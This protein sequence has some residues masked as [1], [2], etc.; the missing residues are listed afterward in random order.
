MEI[1]VA[2][3]RKNVAVF[4]NSM[5]KAFVSELEVLGGSS[6]VRKHTCTARARTPAPTHTHA[7]THTQHPHTL[8]HIHKQ[9]HAHT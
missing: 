8:T 2:I 4:Y 7:H 3:S 9:A 6:R 1:D 5:N